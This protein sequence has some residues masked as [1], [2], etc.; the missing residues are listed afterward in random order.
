[1]KKKILMIASKAKAHINFRGDLTKEIIDKDY[2]VT[3]IVPHDLYKEEL[4]MLGVKVV[5]MPYRL[6][7]YDITNISSAI[8]E[9]I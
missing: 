9:F 8:F 7:Y 3:L 6:C 1:M 4:E 2:E 5:V